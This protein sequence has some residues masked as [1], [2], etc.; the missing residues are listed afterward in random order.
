MHGLRLFSGAGRL[1]IALAVGG[2][3][4]GIAS[5]VQADIPDNG[6]IQ[7]C[8]GKAG[9]QFKGQLRVRDSSQGEQCRIYE[10]P[11]NWNQTGPTGPAGVTGPTG[12]TGPAGVLGTEEWG[13]PSYLN[14][15]SGCPAGTTLQSIGTCPITGTKLLSGGGHALNYLASN[16]DSRFVLVEDMPRY[17]TSNEWTTRAILTTPATG[18]FEVDTFTVCT[19]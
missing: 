17:G 19:S 13:F 9:T 4:F 12:P 7:G 5:V 2:A 1:L 18:T 15:S 14:C 10:S 16:F 8:Y 6:V 11:L 3:V